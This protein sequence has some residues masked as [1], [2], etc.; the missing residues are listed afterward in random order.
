MQKVEVGEELVEEERERRG[1]WKR[2]RW[3]TDSDSLLIERLYYSD[4]LRSRYD[5][6]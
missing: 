4:I 1:I 3:R 5:S 2:G 6:I